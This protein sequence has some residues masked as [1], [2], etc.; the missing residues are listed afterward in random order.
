MLSAQAAEV[1]RKLGIKNRG[2]AHGWKFG[3]TEPKST[4]KGGALAEAAMSQ[5]KALLFRPS[6]TKNDNGG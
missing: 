5:L 6:Q 2:Q 4:P 1:R 3:K